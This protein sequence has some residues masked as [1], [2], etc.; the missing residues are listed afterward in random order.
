MPEPKNPPHPEPLQSKT[1]ESP[2]SVKKGQEDYTEAKEKCWQ[3][4]SVEKPPNSS[5]PKYRSPT[6][7]T[8]KGTRATD[9][10]VPHSRRATAQDAGADEA[11]TA[12]KSASDG[13]LSLK[14][15]VRVH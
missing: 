6:Y 1:K 3:A 2:T 9:A 13:D 4:E 14:S 10:C 7:G 15:E 12:G 5:G 11:S 8:T